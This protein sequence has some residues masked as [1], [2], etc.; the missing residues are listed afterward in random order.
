M[1]K[2][3]KTVLGFAATLVLCVVIFL[4]GNYLFN[5]FTTRNNELYNATVTLANDKAQANVSIDRVY[6]YEELILTDTTGDIINV[7]GITDNVKLS[8]L[9]A[10]TSDSYAGFVSYTDAEKATHK[11]MIESKTVNLEVYQEGILDYWNIG[12]YE[13]LVTAYGLVY[14][15]ENIVTYQ[16]SFNGERIPVLYNTATNIYYMFVDADVVMYVLSSDMPFL[17]SDD[18]VTVHFANPSI[19]VLDNHNYNMYEVSAANNT[20]NELLNKGKDKD[21]EKGP[22]YESSGVVGTAD[23]YTSFADDALRKEM[24]SYGNFKWDANGEAEGTTLTIDFTSEEAKK[25]QWTLTENTYSY[26]RAG[27]VVNAV[28]ATRGDES[29]EVSCNI[30]NTIDTE[31]P[32]V[33]VLK[34]LDSNNKLLGISVLDYRAQPIASKGVALC[35]K[36]VTKTDLNTSCNNIVAVQFEVY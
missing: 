35:R 8:G 36:T 28:S 32:F 24:V 23:T 18:M 5:V 6:E 20:K 10:D 12:S 14:Q 4:E 27:L 16:Q 33:L 30:N 25:S 11:F 7:N 17:L 31:R 1:N 15:P 13:K 29:F 3:V 19:E 26:T 9:L 2:T 22:S 34:Y 21:T